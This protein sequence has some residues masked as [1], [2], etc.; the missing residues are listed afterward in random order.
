MFTYLEEKHEWHPLVIGV[1][2]RCILIVNIVSKTRV[3]YVRALGLSSFM[4]ESEGVCDPTIRIDHMAWHCSIIDAANGIT[5]K[6]INI[7]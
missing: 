5:Y 6:T 7:C 3:S 1:V 2:P 4:R